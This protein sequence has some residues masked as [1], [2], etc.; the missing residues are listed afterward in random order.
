MRISSALTG[1]YKRAFPLLLFGIVGMVVTAV[2]QDEAAGG[3]LPFLAVPILFMGTVWFFVFRKLIW[4]L[5]DEVEDH[6]DYLLIRNRG[7]EERIALSNIMNISASTFINPPRVTLRLV[8]PG[9][10]GREVT[11]SPAKRFSLNPFAKHPVVDD[12]IERAHRARAQH[13]IVVR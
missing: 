5:V 10:F 1:F 13:G 9:R 3:S 2:L 12:L 8:T 6:G 4:D 11:F 7:D